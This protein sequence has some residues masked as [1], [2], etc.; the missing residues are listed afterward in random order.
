MI[1][2]FHRI[3]G[4]LLGVL[5]AGCAARQ[6]AP[7]ADSREPVRRVELI[8]LTTRTEATD[9]ASLGI[10]PFLREAAKLHQEGKLGRMHRL[11][12]R[13]P[14]VALEALRTL[15]PQSAQKP[16]LQALAAAYDRLFAL[17]DDGPRWASAL[18]DAVS[19]P[20]AHARNFASCVRA[21]GLME[22]G[23][24]LMA[25]QQLAKIEATLPPF[26]RAEA[27]RLRGVAALLNDQP[28]QAE[29]MWREARQLAQNDLGFAAELDLLESMAL[30]RTGQVEA[31]AKAWTQAATVAAARSGDPVL[32]ER[33]MQ[34]KPQDAS[35]PD[36]VRRYVQAAVG[37]IGTDGKPLVDDPTEALL[38]RQIG[39]WRLARGEM[40]QALLAFSRSETAAVSPSGQGTARIGQ[41]RALLAI[42]QEPPAIAILAAL[43]RSPEPVVSRQALALHGALQVQRGSLDQGLKML[44]QAVRA[45][46]PVRWPG[47]ARAQ[48]DL[49]LAYL[50]AGRE[51]D[52]MRWLGEAQAAFL[53]EGRLSDLAQSLANEAAYWQ[54]S[55][56]SEKARAAQAKLERLETSPQLMVSGR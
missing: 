20:E 21:R 17:A 52:G 3:A 23:R 32:W 43:A 38:W 51:E 8:N 29:A 16:E 48:A 26:I 55:G 13:Y 12:T 10:E 40:K 45:E 7:P 22:Q 42:G 47:F 24:F 30:R 36:A 18:R 46:S 34:F 44:E 28:G 49:A 5:L 50:T 1:R 35:W 37:I 33:L 4:W 2:R 9:P 19:H 6:P 25:Y 41:A 31:A 14:D 27:M 53:R 39:E 56:D 54:Q 15:D 11:I